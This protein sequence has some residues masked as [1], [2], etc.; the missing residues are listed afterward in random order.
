MTF[1]SNL[2]INAYGDA[3]SVE[4]QNFGGILLASDLLV[5]F[6]AN[7]VKQYTSLS[8]MKAD[9]DVDAVTEAQAERFWAVNPHAK[10][11]HLAQLTAAYA[12]LKEDL[13]VFIEADD[14]W[15]AFALGGTAASA[16]AKV[17]ILEAAEW[18]EANERLFLA[19]SDEAGVLTKTASNV[20]ETL[21]GFSYDWTAFWWYGVD[22]TLAAL[23]VGAG[24]LSADPDAKSASWA[25]TNPL[26]GLTASHHSSAPL[27]DTEFG[28]VI[29][30]NGNTIST[31]GGVVVSGPGVTVSGKPISA[32][33]ARAWLK[34][35]LREDVTQ[36]VLDVAARKE[37][38]PYTDRGIQMVGTPIRKRLTTGAEI[39][40]F[41]SAEDEKNDP[42]GTIKRPWITLPRRGDVP[43]ADVSAKILRL[44]C[45]AYSSGEIVEIEINAYL[46]G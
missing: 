31:F 46:A 6:S 29:D 43:D 42:T 35:R 17:N 40:H 34:A 38:I 26:P 10:T 39:G 13:A 16:S 3:A 1:D 5:A 33:I 2:T 28:N 12:S 25:Y 21:E 22:D 4:R 36:F 9:A 45:G 24:M 41:A 15:F 30:Q 37:K 44:S 8:A 27:D 11:L 18:A 23:E 32:M 19:Q 7:E 14:E 20:L